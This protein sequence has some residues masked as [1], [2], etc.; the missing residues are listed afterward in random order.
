MVLS[1]YVSYSENPSVA[2]EWHQQQK[3][4]GTRITLM[5]SILTMAKLQSIAAQSL[6]YLLQ[7]PEKCLGLKYILL[8]IWLKNDKDC[9]WDNHKITTTKWTCIAECLS[10]FIKKDHEQ[11]AYFIMLVMPHRF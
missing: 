6:C 7:V 2:I 10:N 1:N 8:L 3:M 5:E 11:N 4:H 9:C